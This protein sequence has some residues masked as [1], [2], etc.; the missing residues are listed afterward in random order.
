[1][2]EKVNQPV[3]SSSG[4]D[5]SFLFLLLTVGCFG[6][7]QFILFWKQ[8]VSEIGNKT[9]ILSILIAIVCH[10]MFT[11]SWFYAWVLLWGYMSLIV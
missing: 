7:V 6:T 1:L 5:N 4:V 9:Y 10:G 3:H 2:I 11:N 8:I